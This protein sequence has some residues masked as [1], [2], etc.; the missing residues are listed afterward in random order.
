MFYVEIHL[1]PNQG[2]NTAHGNVWITIKSITGTGKILSFGKKENNTEK[3]FTRNLKN[4]LT[5]SKI[6]LTFGI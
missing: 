5:F 4:N 1:N 3:I 6:I 2:R